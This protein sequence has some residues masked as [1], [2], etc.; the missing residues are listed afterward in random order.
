M[1][2]SAELLFWDPLLWS[3]PHKSQGGAR[4]PEDSLPVL[5]PPWALG[6]GASR[7]L[8][9]PNT[10]SIFTDNEFF[11]LDNETRLC[12]IAP[13]GWREQPQ[14]KTPGVN[15]ALFLRIKVSVSPW[16]CSSECCQ[17]ARLFL[18]GLSRPKWVQGQ[19]LPL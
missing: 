11:F 5:P 8:H 19:T 17:L 6:S 7:L 18:K 13:E 2:P 1:E 3:P 16:G 14:K 10:I 15:F 12:K 4:C 9:P